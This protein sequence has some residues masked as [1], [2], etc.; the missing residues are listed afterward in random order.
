VAMVRPHFA[1]VESAFFT[2]T[3]RDDV[4]YA[5]GL[6]MPRN[7]LADWRRFL[8]RHDLENHDWVVAAQ[9]HQERDIL[10][11]HALVADCDERTRDELVADWNL[12]RGFSSGPRLTDGGVA[13]CTRYALQQVREEVTF[14]WRLS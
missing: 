13:Y 5:G 14:D 11:L 2:G 1:E 6:M 4:G 3:Y 9:R 8:R 12:T 7:V 10:H